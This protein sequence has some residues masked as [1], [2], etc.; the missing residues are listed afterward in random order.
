MDQI[1]VEVIV[2]QRRARLAR[3]GIVVEGSVGAGPVRPGI[4]RH[5]DR[6]GLA[7]RGKQGGKWRELVTSDYK[8]QSAPDQHSHSAEHAP[9][10]V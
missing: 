8:H 6:E 1:N 9:C 5:P 4:G 7:T 10:R 2:P 3:P